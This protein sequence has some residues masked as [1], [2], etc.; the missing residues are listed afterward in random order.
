MQ[1]E[2]KAIIA[3]YKPRIKKERDEL[4]LRPNAKVPP[5]NELSKP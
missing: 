1:E 3:A 2:L 4:G 5:P